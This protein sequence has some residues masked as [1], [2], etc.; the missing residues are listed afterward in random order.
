LDTALPS[1][2]GGE[3]S[4]DARDAVGWW[5]GLA[6]RRPGEAGEALR[7]RVSARLALAR[8][9]PDLPYKVCASGGLPFA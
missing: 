3:R 4:S 6:D 2:F 8:K 1:P 9:K 7:G 5:A